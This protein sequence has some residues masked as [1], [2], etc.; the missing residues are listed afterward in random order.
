MM[1]LRVVQRRSVNAAL[2]IRNSI[3]LS[4][5]LNSSASP[6]T[7][8][9]TPADLRKFEK[10]EG[11][12]G[13]VGGIFAIGG[14]LGLFTLYQDYNAIYDKIFNRIS[15]DDEILS[16]VKDVNKKKRKGKNFVELPNIKNK[17]DSSVPGVYLWG[18]NSNSIV[19]NDPKSKE[20]RYPIRY[21][22]FDG[23]Y[24]LKLNISEHS[25]LAIDEKGDLIQWGKGYSDSKDPEYTIKGQNLIDA[26]IS[27][28]LIYA[29]NNKNEVL[30]IPESKSDQ[31]FAKN[32]NKWKF[33]SKG[34]I[35]I[36]RLS[37]EIFEKGEAVKDLQTGSKHLLILTNLG[38]VYT[39]S[40]GLKQS[41]GKS[42]GQFGLLEYNQFK[43]IPPPNELKEVKLLNYE[44][45]SKSHKLTPRNIVQIATGSNHS[46]ALDSNGELYSFGENYFGQLGH[47]INGYD[48]EIV[49]IPKKIDLLKHGL[50]KRDCFPKVTEIKAS[51]DSTFAKILPVKM[52]KVIRNTSLN[53]STID[54]V[55]DE[56]DDI[57]EFL[58]GF[59]S[60]LKGQ[61]GSAQFIHSQHKPSKI[62]VLSDLKDY[63]ELTKQLEVIKPL[64]WSFNT[65]HSFMV[66]ENKDVLYWGG[67]DFGELGNGKKSRIA[68]PAVMP[69]LIEPDATLEKVNSMNFVNRLNLKDNQEIIAG[70]STGAIYYKK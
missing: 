11:W 3:V 60:N 18:D 34:S 6:K 38:N 27:N 54:S 42:H 65:D 15:D 55:L 21:D 19:S 1:S 66:L 59:G 57:E 2:T 45:N 39:S 33:W 46:I 29:L 23:K 24:L 50:V 8:V 36:P 61:L 7:D 5:R 14:I 32:K 69:P 48:N 13:V 35:K 56:D 20:V 70:V 9:A 12:K 41:E 30:L 25:A 28:G 58:I 62:K 37:T 4:K 40:T 17:N 10:S 22:W 53:Q 44:I 31:F 43:N 51:G 16:K 68:K 49:A 67:N 26:K 63:N 52:F 64:K 47:D